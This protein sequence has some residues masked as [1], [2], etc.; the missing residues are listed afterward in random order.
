MQ[1]LLSEQASEQFVANLL[2]LIEQKVDERLKQKEK[3][4][5]TQKEVKEEYDCNHQN[6]M[7]WEKAGLR[8]FK[9]GK[10]VVYDRKDIEATFEKLKY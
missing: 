2:D 1:A 7:E 10:H 5:L 6:I 4:Y 8:R 9:K 3:R